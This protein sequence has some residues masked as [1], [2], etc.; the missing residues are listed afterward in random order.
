M[1]QLRD[2]FYSIFNRSLANNPAETAAFFILLTGFFGSLVLI[3]I[4]HTRKIKRKQIKAMENKWNVLCRRFELTDEEADFI[5]DLSAHM[6]IPEK[7]YLLLVNP[8][9][10]TNCL[11]HY[12]GKLDPG[13]MEEAI[14]RKT[15]LVPV[16]E[17][18]KGIV[19]H[20]RKN[21]RKH[22]DIEAEICPIEYVVAN[23]KTRMFDISPGGCMVENTDKRF[24]PGDDLKLSFTL[25]KKTYRDIP[26]E[27]IRVSSANTILHLK[28]ITVS[29]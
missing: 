22:I 12:S 14:I 3:N 16:S 29:S 7:K 19:S 23:R 27:V 6:Q 13:S 1:E 2:I 21:S 20:R 25:E 17:Q 4:Y 10:F 24:K 26:A 9:L 18:M 5:K 15:G 28:F 8:H 11:K